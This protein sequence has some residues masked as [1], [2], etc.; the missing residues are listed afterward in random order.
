MRISKI[1]YIIGHRASEPTRTKN[2]LLTTEWLLNVKQK[3]NKN[4]ELTILV[5]EQDVEP[6]VKDILPSGIE[7]IWLN[8]DGYYNRGWVFNVG[9]R[10][11]INCT[12]FFF[13]DNDIIMKDNEI[14]HVFNECY[15]YNAV[16][17]YKDVYDSTIQIRKKQIYKF[18]NTTSISRLIRQNYISGAR[19]NICF[20]GGVMG[21]NKK[22]MIILNGWDE[23]FRGRGYEDY[24]FTSK[25]KLFIPN[26]KVFNFNALHI[27]HPFEINTTR[28]ISLK[29]DIEYSKYKFN[30]YVALLMNKLDY[31]RKDL[32]NTDERKNNKIPSMYKKKYLK[33]RKYYYC[34]ILKRVQCSH[35]C[36]TPCQVYKIFY[37]NLIGLHNCFTHCPT[38]DCVDL[39]ECESGD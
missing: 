23:R 9:F 31:G 8:N 29:I 22:S 35:P 24:A 25:L 34:K 36:C 16:N 28:E 12:Y 38:N 7:Y 14:I 17:P 1:C 39:N 6:K 27:Y 15:N 4:V 21:I 11:Y 2:L 26:T 18:T 5:V 37:Y 3:L 10:E 19:D 32:Y 33:C 13:A 30:D 20:S